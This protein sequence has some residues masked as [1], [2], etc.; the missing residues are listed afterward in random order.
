VV[1]V[2]VA[3]WEGGEQ[4]AQARPGLLVGLEVL[5]VAPGGGRTLRTSSARYV[6]ELDINWVGHGLGRGG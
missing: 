3:E 5:V 2:E 6:R 4:P 1:R